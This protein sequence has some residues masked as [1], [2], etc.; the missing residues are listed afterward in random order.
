MGGIGAYILSVIAAALV[1]SLCSTL[2]RGHGFA[3]EV[4]KVLTGMFLLLC[5]LAPIRDIRLPDLS[6]WMQD[7]AQDGKDAAQQGIADSQAAL[8]EG[9]KART[10]AYILNRAV[11]LG[12]QITADVRLS[13]DSIP[14]PCSVTICGD[15]APYA[16]QQLQQMLWQEL[17]IGK[18][19][20]IWK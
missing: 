14:V 10:E 20:Q 17:G 11:Q 1:C 5:L 9:I 12:A 6:G 7:H 15:I 2:L 8:A 18:E 4:G 3:A 19:D 16:K 13:S